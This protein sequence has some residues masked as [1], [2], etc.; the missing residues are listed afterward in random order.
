M[1]LKVFLGKK[2]I[3]EQKYASG[4]TESGVARCLSASALRRQHC[5]GGTAKGARDRPLTCV[6][7]ESQRGPLIFMAWPGT[8]GGT[9]GNRKNRN[10]I[11]KSV[12]RV[13]ADVN[14]NRPKEY[15]NYESLTLTWG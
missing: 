5:A 15:W 1:S 4:Q 2:R 11:V 7:H 6:T 9:I 12:A 13:Y 3:G 14:V 8:T 10:R